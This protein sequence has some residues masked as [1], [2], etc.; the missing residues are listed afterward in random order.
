SVSANTNETDSDDWNLIWSDEFD[1]SGINM[2]NWSYDV[3]EN[4]RWNDEIQSYTENNAYIEDGSL[5][6]EAREEEIT[7]DDGQTYDYS[8]AKL[9]TKGKQNWQYGK[10]EIKAKMPTG[11]GIWPALWMMPED[12]PFYGT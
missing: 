4:G 3:P 11:Q 12:E 2:D 6:L 7:E 5:I 9:I 1:G 8:S 10:I